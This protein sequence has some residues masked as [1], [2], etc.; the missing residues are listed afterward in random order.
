MPDLETAEME[1]PDVET[2]VEVT[3]EATPDVGTPEAEVP[4]DRGR[5]H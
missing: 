3:D 5:H 4:R 1:N 2:A